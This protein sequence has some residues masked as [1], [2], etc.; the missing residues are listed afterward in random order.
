MTLLTFLREGS[1]TKAQGRRLMYVS[2]E[3]VIPLVQVVNVVENDTT[4]NNTPPVSSCC[5]QIFTGPAFLQ[6]HV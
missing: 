2:L 5:M 6:L 1:S 3:N 4:V